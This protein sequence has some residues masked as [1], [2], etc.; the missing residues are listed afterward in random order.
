MSAHPRAPSLSLS[1]IIFL[2]SSWPIR[3]AT[4]T[5]DFASI[6]STIGKEVCW[7]RRLSSRNSLAIMRSNNQNLYSSTESVD[8]VLRK[9][10]ESVQEDGLDLQDS[11]M[12]SPTETGSISEDD[13]TGWLGGIT[14]DFKTLAFTLK[15]TAGGVA[16]FVKHSAL[17]VA[18]EIA[19]LEGEEMANRIA[20]SDSY[21]SYEGSTSLR[22]PWEVMNSKGDF[23]EDE[24]LKDKIIALSAKEA[25]FLHPFSATDDAKRP[26]FLLDEPRIHLIRRIL[27]LDENL[28]ATHARLSGR[29]DVKET[30]F[31]QNY[32]HNCELTKE[33]HFVLCPRTV[34]DFEEELDDE[35]TN[36]EN[37][38]PGEESSFIEVPSPPESQKSVGSFVNVTASDYLNILP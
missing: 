28:A 8:D 37:T 16:S 27:D 9:F 38:E 3:F 32:F 35:D 33:E 2:A 18:S 26:E 30:V 17:A 4:V 24:I 25:A 31:W 5:S 14:A 34:S 10:E 23:V 7:R 15:E 36:D 22:F 6:A 20:S 1:I 29:S 12:T 11:C 13:S 21:E 19:H